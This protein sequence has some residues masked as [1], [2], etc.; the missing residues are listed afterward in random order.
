MSTVSRDNQ[1]IRAYR[2]KSRS[3]CPVPYEET[4]SNVNNLPRK[5]QNAKDSF[6]RRLPEEEENRQEKSSLTKIPQHHGQ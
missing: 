1:K 5:S 2:H 4:K 3:H 6:C